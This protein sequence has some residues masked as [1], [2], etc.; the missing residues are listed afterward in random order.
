MF[1]KEK[2][3]SSIPEKGSFLVSEENKI[4]RNSEIDEKKFAKNEFDFYKSK[5]RKGVFEAFDIELYNSLELDKIFTDERLEIAFYNPDAFKENINKNLLST[6]LE[7][8]QI[9]MNYFMSHLQTILPQLEE[10]RE[11]VLNTYL[12]YKPNID[13]QDQVDI[14]SEYK[15]IFM[16]VENLLNTG[17][18]LL[19]FLQEKKQEFTL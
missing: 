6:N 5:E 1:N 16:W 7:E 13:N 11:A 8:V 15:K 12:E 9:D 10:R 17:K 18:D 4:R 3:K 19:D 14:Q 2:I